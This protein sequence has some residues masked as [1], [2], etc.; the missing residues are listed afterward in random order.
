MIFSQVRALFQAAPSSVALTTMTKDFFNSLAIWLVLFQSDNLIVFYLSLLP[1]KDIFLYFFFIL[2][3]IFLPWTSS[4]WTNCLVSEWVMGDALQTCM[5]PIWFDIIILHS[6][7]NNKTSEVKC[8][9][10]N[11]CIEWFGNSKIYV[12]WSHMPTKS[13]TATTR[14]PQKKT[15]PRILSLI[16]FWKRICWNTIDYRM[17]PATLPLLLCKAC[18]S[19]LNKSKMSWV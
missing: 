1:K 9:T 5:Y 13:G 2:S 8:M 15:A 11:Q 7:V 6:K 18:T 3:T 17:I 10:R 16:L 4:F 19:P 14:S 12:S